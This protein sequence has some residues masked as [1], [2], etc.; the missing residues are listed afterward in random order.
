MVLQ[1]CAV[2]LIYIRCGSRVSLMISRC[3]ECQV[4]YVATLCWREDVTRLQCNYTNLGIETRAGCHWCPEWR[5]W[6]ASRRWCCPSR[7]TPDGTWDKQLSVATFSSSC[8]H[9][10]DEMCWLALV[11][12]VFQRLCKHNGHVS[13]VHLAKREKSIS[14]RLEMRNSL[15]FCNWPCLVCWLRPSQ[16]AR[17]SNYC[18]QVSFCQ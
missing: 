1:W 9:K 5:L 3:G 7:D 8:H 4:N 18:W 16:K 2:V 15:I 10:P 11:C 14:S 17:H 12:Q 13:P 6:R